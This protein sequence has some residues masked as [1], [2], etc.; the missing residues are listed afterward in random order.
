MEK[1]TDLRKAQEQDSDIEPILRWKRESE[2]RP[3]WETV[4][5]HS[6]ATKLYWAQWRSL[7]L[8]EGVLHRIWE[9]PAGDGVVWQLLL[10]KP[11]R[12]TAFL[13][14]H[15]T[16]TSGHMG[17]KKTLDRIRQRFYWRHC[18]RDI[19]S[20]C[21][22]CDLCSSQ[23]G[24][25]KKPRAPM[26]QY[27]VGAPSERVAM[28]ILGPLPE[29]ESGN[30]YLLLVADY[31]TK[32]PEAYALPNQE[33]TTVAEVFVR[34][35]VCR[36]G[37]PLELHSDQGRNFE[38]NVFKEMCALLGIKKTRTTPL[39]P[40]SDGMIERMNR[41]LEAQL[42]KFVDDHHRDW[43]YYIPYLMMALHS[44][45]HKSTKCTPTM[46]QLGRELCLPI[47]LL[48]GR[49]EEPTPMHSYTE[50]VQQSLEQVHLFA[51]ENLRLASD[52]MKDYYDLRA[53]IK[54]FE[55]G[56]AVWLH[57]PQQKPGHSPKLMRAW[58]G[59]YTVIKAINDVVY[60]IQLTSRSKP[61]V[62]HRNHLWEYTGDNKPNRFKS[63]NAPRPATITPPNATTTSNQLQTD[64]SLT[65]LNEQS[66]SNQEGTPNAIAETD[67]STIQPRCSSR[68]RRPVQ[69][70]QAAT[71]SL[72]KQEP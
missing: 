1:Y 10:P 16:L 54:V 27:N 7:H 8:R 26:S 9:T 45:T 18:Q 31:F 37:V 69:H 15:A 49:P 43:D 38:S 23:R 67:K 21:N 57:N 46:M 72:L 34:E 47:D 17:I 62:V 60:R 65:I 24:P 32:W 41:T 48:L 63:S 25:P 59:P 28:D 61:K 66:D 35:Y 64:L 52:K 68:P 42:S 36:F 4:A 51:R 19:K 53:N 40:Q 50:K 33:A 14:L 29:S 6:P 20:W 44:A 70:Y 30:K 12:K 13:Q 5:P 71:T 22:S 2:N 55:A 11:M 56:D 39:H 3:D 58:E